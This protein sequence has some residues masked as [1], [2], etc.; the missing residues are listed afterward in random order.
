MKAIIAKKISDSTQVFDSSSFSDPNFY[1]DWFVQDVKE[2]IKGGNASNI[3]EAMKIS[4]TNMRAIFE[5]A[6]KSGK[7]EANKLLIKK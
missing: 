7:Q 4:E 1:R 2:L 6:L 3:T 5:S